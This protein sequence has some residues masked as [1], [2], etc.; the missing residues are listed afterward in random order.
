MLNGGIKK[1]EQGV[2]FYGD[3]PYHYKMNPEYA[4]FGPAIINGVLVNPYRGDP[5]VS[6][7]GHVAERIK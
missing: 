4:Y 2:I 6:I 3:K 7:H 1:T 5:P